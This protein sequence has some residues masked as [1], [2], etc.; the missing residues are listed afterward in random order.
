MIAN[1]HD[2][3]GFVVGQIEMP[4][5]PSPRVVLASHLDY[6]A[7]IADCPPNVVS[8]RQRDRYFELRDYNET[9]ANYFEVG[10]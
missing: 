4:H 2:K 5:P 3:S 10:R 9:E 8:F 6:T 7:H 1:L